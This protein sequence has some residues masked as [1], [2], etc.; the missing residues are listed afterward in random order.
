MPQKGSVAPDVMS[1]FGFVLVDSRIVR[2]EDIVQDSQQIRCIGWGGLKVR[3]NDICVGNGRRQRCISCRLA[4]Q[5]LTRTGQRTVK[6]GRNPREAIWFGKVR[7]RKT[8][9][10]SAGIHLTPFSI[11]QNSV[12][13]HEV[14]QD[15]VRKNH[16][17]RQDSGFGST[18]IANRIQHRTQF[19]LGRFGMRRFDPR[20]CGV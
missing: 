17:F 6:F 3:F 11:K 1:P 12:R 14:P 18:R 4:A 9:K 7:R 16:K 19:G 8:V 10:D 2:L 13:H 20:W 5:R 15:Y